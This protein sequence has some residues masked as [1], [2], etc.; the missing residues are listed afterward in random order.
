MF[1]GITKNRENADA[2]ARREKKNGQRN[3]EKKEITT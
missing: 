2:D 3:V 1:L